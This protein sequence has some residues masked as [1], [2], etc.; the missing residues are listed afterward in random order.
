[1]TTPLVIAIPTRQR[2]ATLKHALHTCLTQDYDNFQI[3]VLVNRCC[4]TSR[5]LDTLSS[6]RV[7]CLESDSD[8]PMTENWERLFEVSLHPDSYV[9]FLGDD[10]GL[11]PGALALAD[12]LIRRH[13]PAV[14]NWEKAEYA[15]PDIQVPVYAN[16]AS[17]RLS[18][19]VEIRETS[20]FL[21]HAHSFRAP[22]HD[23]PGIYSSFVSLALLDDVR[24]RT[25][26]RFFQSCS[27]DVYS[28]YAL[29]GSIDRFL[30][31]RFALSVNGASGRSNGISYVHH[32][33]SVSSATFRAGTAIHRSLVHAPSV[34]IAE[35]DGLLTARDS[36]PNSFRPYTFDYDALLR[37]LKVE[38]D[39]EQ[40]ERRHA[41]LVHALQ[42]IAGRNHRPRP[43]VKSYT[44]SPSTKDRLG[45]VYGFSPHDMRL[46]IDL[47]RIGVGNIAQACD[48]LAML[49]PLENIDGA[50][51]CHTPTVKRTLPRLL[52]KLF[53]GPPKT[54]TN[55]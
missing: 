22:Y 2:L 24:R 13:R 3:I 35:A 34:A 55:S 33:D 29:A 6:P 20:T 21:D 32:F 38:A 28:C 42:V 45:P 51:S 43:C 7:R 11:L 39:G 52:S 1:V 15:W 44:D 23:G 49:N 47:G 40:N 50:L 18:K 16:Y 26:G 5:W 12:H 37:R 19:A 54:I 8:L 14:L 25:Q 9:F 31:C 4:S 10:D 46:T 48:A 36:L 17:L 27:P 53:S 30:R 41:N